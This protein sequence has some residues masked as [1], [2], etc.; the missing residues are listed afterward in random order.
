MTF[1]CGKKAP[2]CQIIHIFVENG[3][4]LFVLCGVVTGNVCSSGK[5]LVIGFFQFFQ[6]FIC[7]DQLSAIIKFTM[8]FPDRIRQLLSIV[9]YCLFF[10]G[11]FFCFDKNRISDV[12]VFYSLLMC[13]GHDFSIFLNGYF[14]HSI[15]VVVSV[16]NVYKLKILRV[17]LNVV[18]IS[19][20]PNLF[21]FF[22][23]VV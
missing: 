8:V 13:F 22:I 7:F 5:E 18:L 6:F 11:C 12:N 4:M 23:W 21:F 15:L 10:V 19:L 1:Y 17:Q 2:T 3:L 20:F 14:W 16:A 9:A